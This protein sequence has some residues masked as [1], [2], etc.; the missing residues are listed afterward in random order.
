L[1][2]FSLSV[3]SKKELDTYNHYQSYN[4]SIIQAIVRRR[5][6]IKTAFSVSVDPDEL[7]QMLKKMG[8]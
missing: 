5:F 3:V 1:L 2:D 7:D 4:Q 6:D 8:L